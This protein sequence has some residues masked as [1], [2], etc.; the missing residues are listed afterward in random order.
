ME[1]KC[2]SANET[3]I[4]KASDWKDIT[5]AIQKEVNL[6]TCHSVFTIEKLILTISCLQ[7][8]VVRAKVQNTANPV[9]K[10]Q[11]FKGL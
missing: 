8:R 3:I 1:G 10:P 7:E 5:M 6:G 2:Y 4:G 9:Q 11:V